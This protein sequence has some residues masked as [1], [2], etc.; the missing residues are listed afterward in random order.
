MVSLTSKYVSHGNR[1]WRSSYSFLPVVWLKDNR[2]HFRGRTVIC[3]WNN[4]PCSVLHIYS[5]LK[6]TEV[7]QIIQIVLMVTCIQYVVW[8]CSLLLVISV[9]LRGLRSMKAVATWLGLPY[10][11]LGNEWYFVV[12]KPPDV[13]MLN[14]PL[15]QVRFI[16]S[17]TENTTPVVLKNTPIFQ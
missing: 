1:G 6:F 3:I 9:T 14:R 13:N 2:Y 15:N 16:E 7:K 4:D 5:T 12:Y 8:L 11:S 10:A 17:G